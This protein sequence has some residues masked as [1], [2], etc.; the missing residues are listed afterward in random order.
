MKK[1]IT[2]FALAV[3]VTAYS[4]GYIVGKERRFELLEWYPLQLEQLA[5]GDNTYSDEM[6]RN[7][8]K[9]YAYHHEKELAFRQMDEVWRVDS[10]RWQVLYCKAYLLDH[11]GKSVLAIQFYERALAMNVDCE[12]FDAG[13]KNIFSDKEAFRRLS[14]CYK[15]K[16]FCTK[17]EYDKHLAEEYK[18]SSEEVEC[19]FNK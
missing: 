3:I 15:T 2:Y 10:V 6:V 5:E 13:G 11:E 9:L 7:V 18:R 1:W 14:E 12:V 4:L 8:V 19:K 17:D 16:Y